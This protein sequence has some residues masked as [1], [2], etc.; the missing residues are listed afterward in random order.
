MK[1]IRE[2]QQMNLVTELLGIESLTRRERETEA[3]EKANNTD[4]HISPESQA[5][6]DRGDRQR[7]LGKYQGEE[8]QYAGR[9]LGT[10][11]AHWPRRGSEYIIERQIFWR[12]RETIGPVLES[13]YGKQVYDIDGVIQVE[14][15]SQRD[16]R[17]SRG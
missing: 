14:N 11:S 2:I 8:I 4:Y 15:D 7:E 6:L 12:V 1:G 16:K 9:Y 10:L 5:A 17:L 3:A 13:D